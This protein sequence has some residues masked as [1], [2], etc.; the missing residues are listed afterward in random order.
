[1]VVAVGLWWLELVGCRLWWVCSR[2]RRE[3]VVVDLSP[4]LWVFGWSLIGFV[5]AGGGHDGFL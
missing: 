1:V 3:E 4:D 5:V 2:R